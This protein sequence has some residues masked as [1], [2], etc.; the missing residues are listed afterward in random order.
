MPSSMVR[1][2][3]ALSYLNLLFS[4]DN[5]AAHIAS[6]KGRKTVPSL[7]PPPPNATAIHDVYMYAIRMIAAINALGRGDSD[8][9]LGGVRMSKNI[10]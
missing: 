7:P 1:C 9:G 6:G 5:N 10:L 3:L 4:G 2:F 8:A